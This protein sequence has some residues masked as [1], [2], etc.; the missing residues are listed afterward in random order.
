LGGV[1]PVTQITSTGTA[2]AAL[3]ALAR[4]TA[5]AGKI[6]SSARGLS[7]FREQKDRW[8]DQTFAGACA[9]YVR[10]KASPGSSLDAGADIAP[11]AMRAIGRV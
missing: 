8:I 1:S 10:S 9:A 6:R 7:R 4:E 11:P 3:D 2:V 5:A